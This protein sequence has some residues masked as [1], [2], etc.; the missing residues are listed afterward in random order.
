MLRGQGLDPNRVESPESAWRVFCEFLAVDIDG[1]ETGPDSD[2]DGFVVSWGRDSRNDGLPSLSFSRQ[3]AVGV[4]AVWTETEWYQPEYWRVSL[5]MFFPDHPALADLDQLN[6]S[7][8]GVYFERPGP[9]MDNA[10]REALWEFGQ[11]PTLQAL[12]AGMPQRSSV[13]LER[14][15]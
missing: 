12:W 8:G 3:L 6:T 11:S 4:R 7:D 1:L 14:I 2:A 5:D 9:E 13:D 15:A 10:I